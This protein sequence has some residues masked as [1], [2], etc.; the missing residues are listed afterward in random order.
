MS[1]VVCPSV[2]DA[3]Q[4]LKEGTSA[5]VVVPIFNA[6]EDA[7]Q[8]LGSLVRH[9]DAETDILLID[10]AS[11]DVRIAALV[12]QLRDVPPRVVLLRHPVNQGFVRTVNES[13]AATGRRD[14]VIV[15]SDVIVGP[16]YLERLRDAAY[17][18]TRIATATP[19]TNH[20][21]IVSVPYR[22]TPSDLPEGLTPEGAAVAV[23][24]ESGRHRPLLPT[25]VGHCMYIKRM[26][27]DLVGPF[28]ETF[29]PGYGEEVDFCQRCT[30][31]GLAHVC[32][33]D[34]FV[35]HRGGA[36][37]GKSPE[38]ERRQQRNERV[39]AERYPFYQSCV[40][41]AASS[42]RSALA[43]AL[44]EARRALL[45]LTVAV[46]ATCIGPIV[47]GT[48][49]SVSETILALARHPRVHRVLALMP[50]EPPEHFIAALR[51]VPNVIAVPAG[52][53][54]G[55]VADVVYR[56]YQLYDHIDLD[57]LRGRGEKLVVAQ[58]D[59]I[60][61]NNPGYFRNPR[62]WLRYRDGTRLALAVADGVAFLSEHSRREAQAEG[63]LAGG[64]PA[65]VVYIGTDHAALQDAGV[66]PGG[67]PEDVQ[68]KGF[69]LCLGADYRH[70][71]RFFALGTFAAMVER[72][73]PGFL[74]MAG[75]RIRDGSSRSM[76]AA[77]LLT[78]PELSSRVL[79]LA[80]VSE[81]GRTWLLEH[82]QLVLHPTLYEGF[83]LVPYEAAMVGTP[84]LT[85]G[86]AALAE[87]L[88]ADAEIIAGWDTAAVADQA[89]GILAN[90]ERRKRLVDALARRAR[91]FSW[92]AA[93]DRLVSLFR[94]VCSTVGGPAIA[95]VEGEEDGVVL[96]ESVFASK[97]HRSLALVGMNGSRHLYELLD[98]VYPQDFHEA[99]R[100]IGQRPG[101]RG[102]LIAVTVFGYRLASAVRSR[103][104]RRRERPV[105]PPE[106]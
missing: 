76:E 10:D 104:I 50:A 78:H 105:E 54:G 94:T 34:V 41:S 56:P 89:M 60:A 4:A 20:G 88:P 87:L 16:G 17:A 48:Q 91:D 90:A 32:A 86:Q 3:R 5:V 47:T 99:M 103:L 33:D 58:L 36:S 42:R 46:D 23:A 9:S 35:Y 43:V 53:H 45:G 44:G 77:H 49:R 1:V 101:L 27:I 85:S 95:A 67:L 39:I 31:L 30:L 14:V 26:A 51:D 7:I 2:S 11:T 93:A 15:N 6:Y 84:C 38:V 73:Y 25:C 28:D 62:D 97:T 96:T 40:H 63:L 92:N 59:L 98:E 70:K 71:N 75:P 21:T 69:V 80:H 106:P 65:A 102:P 68:A 55:S 74:V 83:G 64:Q 82:A 66:P 57:R 100:A 24:A 8:C 61:F 18:D 37:F 81:A 72:G 29:S 52:Q 13:F 79:P 19:L 22:N 12:E